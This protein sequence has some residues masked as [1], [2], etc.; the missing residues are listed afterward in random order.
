MNIQYNGSN[1][2]GWQMQDN[3]Q[4][5]Q[6]ELETALLPLGDGNR[7]KIIGAGRTDTGVH[8]FGQ[9]AH[10]ELDTRLSLK[11][12]RNAI[13]ART[14]TDIEV[15]KVEI[16]DDKFHARFSAKERYYI[17]QVYTGKSLLYQNQSWHI[18]SLD[19][20]KLN[21]TAAIILGE[22]DFLSI[23]KYNPELDHT[24]CTVY[25]SKWTLSDDMI[26]FHVKANRFLHHM[27]RYLVGTMIAINQEKYTNEEFLHILN[28]PQRNVRIF[29]A[30]PN[31][32]IL[33][34]VSY[35]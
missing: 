24:M 2:F 4:T 7:V 21:T 18:P 13:N 17:Y 31:G 16:V 12:I 29:K 15:N 1:Y 32:L 9:V 8:A 22:H 5:I 33:K 26:T 30:P 28:N 10:F 11:E 35:E 25:D 27:V 3:A 34:Q 23:S 6:G 20:E 19:V 14:K